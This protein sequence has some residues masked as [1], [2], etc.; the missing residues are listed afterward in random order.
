MR[1]QLALQASDIHLQSCRAAF[2]SQ[3]CSLCSQLNLSL[4]S[5]CKRLLSVLEAESRASCML[6]KY[7]TTELHGVSRKCFNRPPQAAV[8]HLSSGSN[9]QLG[10]VFC[11]GYLLSITVREG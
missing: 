4:T 1:F 6:D 5:W 9:L 7:S 11:P 2:A 10:P 3:H 8:S